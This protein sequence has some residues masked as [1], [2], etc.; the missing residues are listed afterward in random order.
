MR[1][2]VQDAYYRVLGAID[3]EVQALDGPAHITLLTR[4]QDTLVARL[5]GEEEDDPKPAAAQ[6]RTHK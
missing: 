5:D 1:E 6:R 3:Q 2:R 4:L